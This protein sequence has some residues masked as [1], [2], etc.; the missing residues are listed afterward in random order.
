MV[1]K[2]NTAA[3]LAEVVLC[4]AY[5]AVTLHVCPHCVMLQESAKLHYGN[6]AD[7]TLTVP[8]FS[9]KPGEVVAIVGRVGCG[10]QQFWL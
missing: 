3:A 10:K 5:V 8:E 6:P 1:A 2:S 9:V 7:F 4:A